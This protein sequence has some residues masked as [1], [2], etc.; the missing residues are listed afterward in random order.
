MYRTLVIIVTYNAM[1]WIDHCLSSVKSSDANADVFIIDN[2]STDG[3]QDYIKHNY[4]SVLFQQS[5]K[6]LGFGKANNIGLRYAVDNGYDYVYLLNQDAWLYSNTISSLIS[7]VRENPSFGII[8]PIQCTA[9][10]QALDL[11]FC[12]RITSCENYRNIVNDYMI[13]NPKAI[14]SVDGIMAAHWFMT[15]DCVKKV[16]GFSPSFPHY[17]EDDNYINRVFY[18]NMDIGI[19]TNIFAVHDR[20][21]RVLSSEKEI[22]LGYTT[23]IYYL[24]N[25]LESFWKG[26]MKSIKVAAINTFRYKSLKPLHYLAK[27]ICDIH[28][29]YNNRMESITT[30]GAFL[31]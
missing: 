13:G 2:G 27:L 16:G 31:N 18:H 28:S 19:A 11:N 26:V 24:S 9:N 17:S 25:P 1:Q 12:K 14:Y 6:N 7:I 30:E 5:L 23:S 21:N 29:I 20:E 22:Y 3:T 8:S 10:M 4:P 15:V